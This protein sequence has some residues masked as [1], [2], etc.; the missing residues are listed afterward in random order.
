[1]Y[2]PYLNKNSKKPPEKSATGSST[3]TA[4]ATAARAAANSKPAGVRKYDNDVLDKRQIDDLEY[5]EV[6]EGLPI[7]VVPKGHI[8]ELIKRQQKLGVGECLMMGGSN[9]T[10][11]TATMQIR[12]QDKYKRKYTR[13]KDII[14]E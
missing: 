6:R 2:N 14:K 10:S 13:E 5:G 4:A 3:R 7:E 9:R 12:D 8:D 11:H 1:M